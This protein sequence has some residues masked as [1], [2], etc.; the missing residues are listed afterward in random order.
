MNSGGAIWGLLGPE[1]LPTT[2][3]LRTLG[4]GSTV[5]FFNDRA[6]PGL[7]GVWF[8]KHPVLALLGVHV[9]SQCDRSNLEVANAIEALGSWLAIHRLNMKQDPRIRGHRKLASV[10]ES[11][12]VYSRVRRPGFH[13]SQPMRMATVQTLPALGLVNAGSARFNA[14]ECTTAGHELMRAFTDAYR[15]SNAS[16]VGLLERWIAGDATFKI[17]DTLSRALAST[18][19]LPTE[20]IGLLHERLQRGGDLEA[21]AD[22]ARRRAALAW[23]ESYRLGAVEMLHWDQRPKEIDSEDHW[24]DLKAGAHFF[25]AR[26]AALDV[27]SAIE[28]HMPAEGTMRLDAGL[29]VRLAEVIDRLQV[30]ANAF[31]ELNHQEMQAT[32]FCRECVARDPVSV[33]RSLVLRDGMVLRMQG[34][35][36]ARGPAF[37]AIPL[38]ASNDEAAT[39]ADKQD[40]EPL[41][42]PGISHRM[43]NL[44]SLNLDLHGELKKALANLGTDEDA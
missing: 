11:D 5:R 42:P 27:L 19:P 7:G 4:L 1:L 34:N 25:L 35:E 32:T 40:D 36:V 28:R 22:S 37:V 2:R 16:L 17:T 39:T 30:A 44:F 23:T 31:L 6:V 18:V 14:F 38:A 21:P 8:A 26:D 12:L 3:R 13:V 33:L 43:R 20:A 9:A 10:A 24:H 15:P 41:W 29:H